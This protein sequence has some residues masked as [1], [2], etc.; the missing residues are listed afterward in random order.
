MADEFTVFDLNGQSSP[1]SEPP[2]VGSGL[3]W[4]RGSYS[5][6]TYPSP[7]DMRVGSGLKVWM[8]IMELES[9]RGDFETVL[10]RREGQLSEADLDAAIHQYFRYKED[11]DAKIREQ[12]APAV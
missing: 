1:A 9:A 10:A 4:V 11:I 3:A 6:N 7:F 2:P 5:G 8:L 12:Y